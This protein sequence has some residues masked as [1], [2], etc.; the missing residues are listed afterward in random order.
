MITAICLGIAVL[1]WLAFSVAAPVSRLLGVA[2]V[3]IV[4]RIMGMILAAIA[5]Q[6]LANG[7]KALLPGLA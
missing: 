6:M 5:L 2:G 3:N 4:T 1:L 7:M